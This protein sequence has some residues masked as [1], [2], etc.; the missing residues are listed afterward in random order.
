MK[1]DV[2][3]VWDGNTTVTVEVALFVLSHENGYLFVLID[4][5]HCNL[6]SKRGGVS[7][8]ERESERQMQTE[9]TRWQHGKTRTAVDYMSCMY[10]RYLEKYLFYNSRP[11]AENKKE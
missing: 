8:R 1:T 3:R 9:A 6:S 10:C 11:E 4:D 2:P 5:E 7:D